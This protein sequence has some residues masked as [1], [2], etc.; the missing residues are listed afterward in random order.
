MGVCGGI[1]DYFKVDPAIVR[2]IWILLSLAYG[3]GI[4]AYIIAWA[5]IPRQGK[6]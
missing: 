4:L 3:F 5:V 1:A 2:L 6:K